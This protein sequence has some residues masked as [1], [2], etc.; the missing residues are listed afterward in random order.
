MRPRLATG[1]LLSIRSMV[2]YITLLPSGQGLFRGFLASLRFA[3]PAGHVLASSHPGFLLELRRFRR[4]VMFNVVAPKMRFHL[5]NKP[6]FLSTL[7]AFLFASARLPA[8]PPTVASEVIPHLIRAGDTFQ[9]S[10]SL[11]ASENIRVTAPEFPAPEGLTLLN[12]NASLEQ[13]V[14][15]SNGTS[16]TTY[17]MTALYRADKP[18]KYQL[19]PVTIAYTSGTDQEG[20][21]ATD[22]MEFEVV[23]DAPRPPSDIVHAVMPKIWIFLLAAMILAGAIAALAWY[24]NRKKPTGEVGVAQTVSAVRTLEQNII[25][26]IKAVPRPSASDAEAVKVYYDKID[27][28]LRKYFSTGYGITTSDATMWEM[29]LRLRA[30]HGKPDSRVEGVLS[31]INDCDW[32][33]YARSRPTQNDIERIPPRASE[34]LTGG[35]EKD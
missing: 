6:L 29:S 32:V 28:I 34:A 26:E 20:S 16:Q 27:E 19:G 21:I 35:V 8:A 33:K 30:K 31:I 24:R 13:S 10:I 17:T 12:P 3:R 23:E 18:G 11:V 1:L 5:S 4:V 7:L 25:E 14:I 22:I 9:V 2:Y 15:L